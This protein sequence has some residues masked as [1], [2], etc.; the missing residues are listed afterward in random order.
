[1]PHIVGGRTAREGEALYGQMA[2]RLAHPPGVLG[3][4]SQLY[5]ASGWTS[6]HYLHRLA[7]PTL[8]LAGD[9]DPAIPLANGRL[10][11]WRIPD[12]QLHIVKGGG[13]AFLLDEPGSVVGVIDEFLR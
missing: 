8:V 3:Y 9:D 7:Q 13:H 1:M 11:A 2:D 10:L 12:A 4:A 5:A 6:A